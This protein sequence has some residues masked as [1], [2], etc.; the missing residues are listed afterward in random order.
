M[1]TAVVLIRAEKGA[2]PKLGETIAAVPGVSEVYSV[3][4]DI[5]LIAMVRAREHED[6]Y[7]GAR[8]RTAGVVHEGRIEAPHDTTAGIR[9]SLYSR[10]S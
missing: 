4:G 3:T 8:Q 5:D 2:V 7:R 10:P 6:R 1:I 9:G